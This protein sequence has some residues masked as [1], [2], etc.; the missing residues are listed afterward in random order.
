M[1]ELYLHSPIRLHGLVR[2]SLS[3]GK[4][5]L[6]RPGAEENHE[7]QSQNSWCEGTGVRTEHQPN[8]SLQPK[9]DQEGF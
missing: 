4:F 5:C 6:F 7:K 9:R 8:T 3:T 1:L 2:N